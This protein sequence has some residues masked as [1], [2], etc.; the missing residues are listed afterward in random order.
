MQTLSLI[1]KYVIIVEP[2]FMYKS[3]LSFTFHF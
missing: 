2:H 3:L 1:L